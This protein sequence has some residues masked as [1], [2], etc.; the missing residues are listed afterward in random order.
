MADH[1][2]VERPVLIIDSNGTVDWSEIRRHCSLRQRIDERARPSCL[3]CQRHA[4]RWRR[5]VAAA[6]AA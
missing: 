6:M 1:R 2:N 5:S 3:E 4:R